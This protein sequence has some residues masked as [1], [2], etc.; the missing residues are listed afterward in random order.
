MFAVLIAFTAVAFLQPQRAYAADNTKTAD[1]RAIY[2]VDTIGG[3]GSTTYNLNQ[4]SLKYAGALYDISAIPANATVKKVT[5][6]ITVLSG[7]D[8][9]RTFTCY[10]DNPSITVGTTKPEPQHTSNSVYTG[11][12]F[13]D[14]NRTYTV[15]VDDTFE[16]VSKL[17]GDS[18]TGNVSVSRGNN[19][20]PRFQSRVSGGTGT[21]TVIWEV[22]NG[23][24]TL[25][26]MENGIG[27]PYFTVEY[28]V[29]VSAP[30]VKTEAPT[31]TAGNTDISAVFN[32]NVTDA[33]G[34]NPNRYL[35]YKKTTDTDWTTL[36]IGTGG[37]G[38]FSS[39][40]VTGL[41]PNTSY[42]VQAVDTNSQGTGSGNILS[43]TT[44]KYTQSISFDALP[45]KIYGDDPFEL[46]AE[47]S[48]NLTVDYESS[49][50]SVATVSGSTVTI[51]GQGSTTITASQSGSTIYDAA[52]IVSQL[53]TINKKQLT[54][55]GSFTAS[56]KIYDGGTSAVISQNSL[57]LNGVVGTD[58]ITLATVVKFDDKN[59]GT[60]KT[61]SI[62]SATISG[63]KSSNYTLST[64]S[65]PT[66]TANIT[67]KTLNLSAFTAD[68]KTYDGT[69]TVLS[70]VGFVDDRVSG[71]ALTFTQ[72]AAFSD[73]NVGTGKTVNY[74]GIAISGG[75]DKNNYTLASGTGT[76]TAD[77]IK[78][79][80]NLTSFGASAKNY[81]GNTSVTGTW[82]EDD[83]VD[84]DKLFLSYTAAF[85]DKNA[86]SGKPVSFTGITLL[87]GVDKDNYSLSATTGAGSADI[88][89]K[90]LTAGGSFTAGSKN[91][92]GDVSAQIT[93]N[94]LTLNGVVSGDTVTLSPVLQF[95][96]KNVGTGKTVSLAAA[97]ALDSTNYALSLTGAPTAVA[98]ITQNV[99]TVSGAVA[100]DKV[101]DGTVEAAISGG[102]LVGIKGSDDVT[103][104]SN[105]GTFADSGVGSG[106]AVSAAM[107][108]TGADAGNYSLTQ[109]TSL[110]ANIIPRPLA[111]KA[112][113]AEKIYGETDPALSYTITS[114]NLITGD[115]LTGSLSR[116]PGE[117][118]GTYAIGQGTLTAITN[119]AITF[120]PDNL[121][122]N[123]KVMLVTAENKTKVYDNTVFPTGQYTAIYSGLTAEEQ[124][125]IGLTGAVTYTG[126][127]TTAKDAG[128]YTIMPSGLSLAESGNYDITYAGGTL[129]IEKRPL[130]LS[131]F[132]ADDKTYDGN[133]SATGTWFDDDRI[134]G[135]KLNITYTAAFDTKNTGEN[136]AVTF[137]DF[138]IGSGAQKNNYTI[139]TTSGTAQALISKKS[140][141]IGTLHADD[142]TYDGTRLA[143]LS[144][145]TLNGVEAGDHVG[146]IGS[147]V[148][149]DADAANGKVVTVTDVS[150]TGDD[151]VNY[152]LPDLS[153]SETTSADITKK[154]LTISG[155]NITKVYDGISTDATA[156][157]T[158]AVLTGVVE[159]DDV[160][161]D[162]TDLTA[163]FADT[164]LGTNKPVTISGYALTGTKAGNYTLLQPTGI[165][166]SITLETQKPTISS[167]SPAN[168][169]QN[170]DMD[171]I[172]VTFDEAVAKA[173]AVVHGDITVYKS[174][175]TVFERLDIQNNRITVSGK[176]VK[177]YL[178]KQPS[179]A[180]S[181][182]VT[183]AGDIILDLAGN[184]FDGI[185]GNTAWAFKTAPAVTVNRLI[186]IAITDG[187]E[188]YHAVADSAD[189]TTFHSTVEADSNGTATVTVVPS[190]LISGTEYTITTAA[191][192]GVTIN[193]GVVT[194][195]D[196]AVT[197]VTLTITAGN[198]T[199]TLV[200]QKEG[201]GNLTTQVDGQNIS[202]SVNA[203]NLR[204]AVDVSTEIA[205]G[206]QMQLVLAI[207]D[208]EA[209]L[210]SAVKT[211]IQEQ[212][213]S[214]SVALYFD[215]TLTMQDI[216]DNTAE[217]ITNTQNPIT[218][219]I[220]IPSNMR[221]GS[222]YK[223]VRT[224]N[225]IREI[226][227]ATIDGN[228][229]VF[230]TDRFSQYAIIYTPASHD[231]TGS[232]DN[233][234]ATNTSGSNTGT[235][236][237]AEKSGLPYYMQDGKKVFIGF[238]AIVDN[239]LKYTAPD[240]VTVQFEENP[241]TFTDIENHWAKANVDFVTQR[242]IFQGTAQNT[243]APQTSMT[244]GMFV[245][246]IGRLYER[247]YGKVTGNTTFTDV[248]T[249]A[250]YA[251]YV[252]WAHENGIVEGVGNNNF[253]PNTQVSREQMASIM[254]R[255]ATFLDKAPKGNWMINV[256]YPDKADIS[257][258]A[259]DAATY[260][261]LTSIITGR[262]SGKF[263]PKA[264][265]T[266]AEVAAVIERFV[267]EILK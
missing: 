173:A 116:S 238:T 118:A 76:A 244:R 70:G 155:I 65:A 95:S 83:R 193:G 71:D 170:A 142:K 258:Y 252:A 242:E 250:Y 130:M 113:P 248:D 188:T 115:S 128:S 198:Q 43:F 141:A 123:K 139:A 108:L 226:L 183:I 177:I 28:T 77:I 129:V 195:T 86:G 182:Y 21:L 97:S 251:K 185:I 259:M 174:N 154:A 75:A 29:P 151:A 133:T 51:V 42:D 266:R 37:G 91:Y 233:H 229:L 89:P 206:K 190:F 54:I 202:V 81:D 39:A 231:D 68:S 246:A 184:R 187:D 20:L 109:P 47:A 102:S 80:L 16:D 213:G 137:S 40:P 204:G 196:P 194:I 84:G 101:Y 117:N 200:L 227:D 38:S 207:E 64:I 32:G 98:D 191:T 52:P 26:S 103:I 94:N 14:G 243:F 85:G 19:V 105:T 1:I 219:K 12:T 253:A 181:Y 166:G 263:E 48:S 225:G 152:T 17:I 201:I 208:N 50:T 143:T 264:T 161:L 100:S 222:G 216:T 127:A 163:S 167:L 240:S 192:S 23:Q 96:D 74:S 159:G 257:N 176:Q 114:G 265:A 209:K 53:L 247:S 106:K 232:T 136:K 221:G 172:A 256:T 10:F 62:E 140:I 197:Q 55:V 148:F 236:T 27:A 215:M 260:C 230:E 158:S 82:I 165:T 150:L 267:K 210:T 189:T 134:S 104:G 13:K 58:D 34:E 234:H 72:T 46:S 168:G 175:G 30:T 25:P 87:S 31:F 59:A 9:A 18:S 66:I 93:T 156:D 67:T 35:K 235:V 212:I 157:I 69:A 90:A 146:L 237:D 2:D 5:F 135:D 205:G 144:A 120:I 92:D 110:T 149:A 63:D 245:T 132:H 99:L 8:P 239:I 24:G 36:D 211:A 73:K 60:G 6:H 203:E 164:S 61:V 162:T 255:F 22:G 121:K 79:T 4:D 249:N 111:I 131:N 7:A 15:T 224:H 33:G 241:K 180:T 218:V 125:D 217:A 119:Y 220:E 262:D 126:S 169:E 214:Q 107:T 261:Q 199:Y 57:S 122:I 41:L 78:R 223:I 160:S 179:S 138:S 254:F 112:N 228:N 171:C 11:F 45:S 56:D 147:A 124:A 3:S 145:S 49:D 186:G 178:T 153:G 44:P 88:K